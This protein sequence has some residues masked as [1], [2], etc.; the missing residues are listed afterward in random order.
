MASEAKHEAPGDPE[1]A[2]ALKARRWDRHVDVVIVVLLG[3][4]SFLAAWAGYQAG[5]WGNL[6]ADSAVI[7]EDLQQAASRATVLGYQARQVDISVFMAWLEAYKRGET[8]LADFYAAR[9]QAVDRLGPAFDAWVATDPFNN[10]DAPL[11]PFEMPEYIVPSLQAAAALDAK[12]ADLAATG[13][14]FDTQSDAYIFLTLLLAVVLFF[15]GITTKIGWR[16]AQVAL[17]GVA[18]VVFAYCLVRAFALPNAETAEVPLGSAEVV[19]TVL[20]TPI[21]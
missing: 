20:A 16:Q 10:P 17:L 9:I 7:V 3:A 2:A 6:K 11:D 21:P 4:A 5:Q 15:G 19:A 14:W 8:N 1:L 12:A 18:W 13:H